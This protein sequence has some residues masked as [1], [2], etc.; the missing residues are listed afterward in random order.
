MVGENPLPKREK[1][2]IRFFARTL[3][4]LAS[5]FWVSSMVASFIGELASGQFKLFTE[6]TVL[7]LL[8]V[9]AV[10]G[11][12]L[13]WSRERLGGT[14]VVIFAL[15]LSSFSYFVAGFNKLLI[16]LITGGPFLL[17]GVLFIFSSKRK[18]GQDSLRRFGSS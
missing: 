17:S 18:S 4:F 15:I 6:G 13:S 12:Y 11:V 16:A 14:L 2:W 3:G 10:S 5:L 7:F 1:S 8:I 9:V